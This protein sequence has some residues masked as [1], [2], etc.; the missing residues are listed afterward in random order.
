MISFAIIQHF[1]AGRHFTRSPMRR[2]P[3]AM[4]HCATS[5]RY[6][7]GAK[8]LTTQVDLR[9]YFRRA[10]MPQCH[11]TRYYVP[12]AALDS[13]Y[14]MLRVHTFRAD[15]ASQE[16]PV[17][18]CRAMPVP[19]RHG[20]GVTTPIGDGRMAELP[21]EGAAS[22][23]VKK[24]RLACFY[25]QWPRSLH[26][27]GQLSLLAARRRRWCALPPIAAAIFHIPPPMLALRHD[28]GSMPPCRR[29]RK[30][31]VAFWPT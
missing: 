3:T 17:G 1:S 26:L 22:A 28:A 7:D 29:P 25:S 13:D 14:M 12:I 8:M 19:P 23:A 5:Y 31:F 10:A 2:A 6:Y 27:K 9:R 15:A 4:P 30:A 11:A 21:A 20:H 18:R 16:M 24:G